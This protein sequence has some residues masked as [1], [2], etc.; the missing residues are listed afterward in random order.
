MQDR[1]GIFE[2]VEP[3]RNQVVLTNEVQG[4]EYFLLYRK[5]LGKGGWGNKLWNFWG[6]S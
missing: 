5:S 1:S 4:Q 2:G 3:K 6:G